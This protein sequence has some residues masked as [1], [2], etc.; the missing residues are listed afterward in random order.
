M[1]EVKWIKI[2]TSMFDSRKIDYIESLPDADAIIVIWIRLLTMAGKC[3][4]GGYIYLTENIPY[5][6]EMLSHKMK[7]PLNTIRLALNV[8]KMLEMINYDNKFLVIV[9]WQKYQNI[10][11]LERIREQTRNRVK[12]HREMKRIT[13]SNINSNVTVTTGNEKEKDEEKELEIDLSSSNANKN[14]YFIYQQNIGTLSPITINRIEIAI[15]DIGEDLVCYAIEQ[16]VD[17]NKK[18][19]KYIETIC[20]SWKKQNVKS[21]SEADNL[22]PKHKD[23]E[24]DKAVNNNK[25]INFKQREYDFDKIEKKALEMVLNETEFT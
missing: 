7:K 6:D 14:P 19:W 11:G 18:S 3:N 22:K 23:K 20:L 12:K 17:Y 10:E 13:A 25:F 2:T 1:S 8:F 5:D 15:K 21:R 9:N 4:A 24:N 16:A